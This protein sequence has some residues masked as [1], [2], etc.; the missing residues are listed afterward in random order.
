MEYLRRQKLNSPECDDVMTRG[1]LDMLERHGYVERAAGYEK[2]CKGKGKG[3]CAEPLFTLIADDKMLTGTIFRPE[4]DIPHKVSTFLL[5][6]AFSQANSCPAQLLVP[7]STPPESVTCFE[8]GVEDS[9]P[10]LTVRSISL[11][12]KSARVQQPVLLTQA[13]R[14]EVSKTEEIQRSRSMIGRRFSGHRSEVQT[15]SPL[16][17][18]TSHLSKKRGYDSTPE[19]ELDRSVQQ[20]PGA[21]EGGSQDLSIRRKLSEVNSPWTF[22]SSAA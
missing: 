18:G 7:S 1:I 12:P 2:A 6:L 11:S 9:E 15:P 3:R 8:N 16:S 4:L 5:V 20:Q 13:T 22:R 21:S 19:P 17:V 14:A 10:D